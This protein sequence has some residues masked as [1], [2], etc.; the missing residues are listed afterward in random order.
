[1]DAGA[2]RH[3]AALLTDGVDFI[4]YDD[5][6]AAVGPELL[7]PQRGS[8]NMSSHEQGSGVSARVTVDISDSAGG[9]YVFMS[10]EGEAAEELQGER[11]LIR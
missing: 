1:M 10:E 5:V 2:A 3:A 7:E 8:V 4:E 9:T 11:A 6:K